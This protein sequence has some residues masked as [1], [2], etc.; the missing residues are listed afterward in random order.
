MEARVSYRL[1]YEIAEITNQHRGHI[2]SSENLRAAALAGVAARDA[3]RDAVLASMKGVFSE[4]EA[5][6]IAARSG[7]YIN[8]H[9]V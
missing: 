1:L 2:Y 7:A 8:E 4:A 9:G 5:L 6:T 3:G